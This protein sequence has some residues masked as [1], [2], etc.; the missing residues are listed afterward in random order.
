M[1]KRLLLAFVLSFLVL[2]IWG[3]LFPQPQQ[4]SAPPVISDEQP[5]AKGK[6]TPPPSSPPSAVIPQEVVAEE[7]T[8][9]TTDKMKVSFSNI[10]GHIKSLELTEYSETMPVTGIVKIQQFD[11]KPFRLEGLTETS[12]QYVYDSPE[13]KV[14]KSYV[15]NPKDYMIDIS[16]EIRA[17][18]S[19]SRLDINKINV[20]SLDISRL[21]KKLKSSRD[22]S[23]FEYTA[24]IND[25][26]QAKGNVIKYSSK[27]EKFVFNQLKDIVENGKVEWLGFR[28]RYFAFI[29][30]PN[31]E[32]TGYLITQS[33]ESMINYEVKTNT[34][35]TYNYQFTAYYGPQKLKVLKEAG[36]NFDK[37]M[38]F[39]GV[40][41]INAVAKGVY[42]ILNSIHKVVPNWGLCIIIL[43]ILINGITYPLTLKSMTSM[44]KMQSLQPQIAKLKEKHKDN[45]QKLSKEQMELFKEHKINPMGGCLPIL[46]QI[47]VFFA[48]YQV[49]WRSVMLKGQGF[50]WIKDLSEPDRLMILPGTYPV[51]GNELNLLPFL[52]GIIMFFQQKISQKNMVV[53][54]P[55]QASQQ[56]MMM[57]FLPVMMV[58]IFYRAA[59]GLTLY[60]NILYL[61]TIFTQWRI[62]KAKD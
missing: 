57:V 20:F 61:T 52:M 30:Q 24:L 10:G 59:S 56:K 33:S 49:L 43:G 62:S 37:I 27:E 17:N 40:G 23:L 6:P 25:K 4:A 31:F 13:A 50:L 60:F 55:T 1:E 22:L 53:S 51:I 5:P 3:R 54:D 39:S 28:N 38:R 41:L 18:P 46:L 2:T 32:S 16:V 15:L 14:V 58:F 19:M 48:L 45:P 11:N 29:I 42:Y 47:P 26:I 12:V 9:L 8:V 34:E 36:H 44:K 7:L 21:D 35:Q